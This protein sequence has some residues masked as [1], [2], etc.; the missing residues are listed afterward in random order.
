MTSRVL[1]DTNVL[2]YRYDRAEAEKSAKASEVCEALAHSGTGTITTQVVCELFNVLTGKMSDRLPR[3]LAIQ[4]VALE[5]DAWPILG[6]DAPIVAQAVTIAAKTGLSIW[7]SQLLATAEGCGIEIVLS[8]D[9]SAGA[10]YGAVRVVN[11]FDG[12][13]TPTDLG[14]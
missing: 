12:D 3:D 4:A 7:D 1:I 11:P 6:V 8:E 9:L 14:G 10:Q 13:F 2:A 5:Y